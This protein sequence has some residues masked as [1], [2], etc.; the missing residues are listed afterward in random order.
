[1]TNFYAIKA[2]ISSHQ[3]LHPKFDVVEFLGGF[4]EGGGGGEGVKGFFLA[5]NRQLFM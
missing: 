2:F 4:L 1:M 3:R 5:E